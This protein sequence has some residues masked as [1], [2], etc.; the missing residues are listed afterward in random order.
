M[1]PVDT[2]STAADAERAGVLDH[3]GPRILRYY[4]RAVVGDGGITRSVWHHSR[5]LAA[6]DAEVVI[7]F[8]EGSAPATPE[9]VE[10][11]SVPHAGWPWKLPLGLDE[12]MEGSD[13][14]VLHSAW[15]LH[16]IRAGK[17]A[18]ESGIPYLL[19]PRGA[20]DPRIL[21]R[22]R[23]LKRAWW[24]L[25]ERRLVHEAR[26][27]HV[28]FEDEVDHLRKLGYEGDVVVAPNGVEIHDEFQWDGGSGGYVLWYGRFDPEHKGVD[29]LLRAM[30]RLAADERPE[31]R[32]HGPD[33]RLG[34]KQEMRQLVRELGL[35][36]WVTIGEPV[37][38]DVKYGLLSRAAGFVYPSR[39]E[40]F[41]NAPAEAASVGVPVLVTPYPLGEHL[42]S[43]GAAHR[44][45]ATPA[46]L[47]EGLRRLLRD[48]A[49]RLGHRGRDVIRE[50]FS[51]E[52]V[53]RSWLEQVRGLL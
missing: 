23:A 48:D 34:G 24:W 9:G 43:R 49:A 22:K 19:E 52:S 5:H 10:L 33:S 25:W 40:A 44:V 3:G 29:L 31:L 1:E 38:G 35:E 17:V 15:A 13:L 8:D 16:N 27:I 42:A 7:A 6:T 37:Y 2:P 32:L 28:F 21:H 39:W 47:A 14:L 50:D 30:A 36:A 26:A 53:A 51:W 20:Y 46:D 4:P 18:R 41:G 11:V 12:V 45:E